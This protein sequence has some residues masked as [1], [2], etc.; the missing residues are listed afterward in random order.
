M[1]TNIRNGPRDTFIINNILNILANLP[2]QN[3]CFFGNFQ[4]I[5]SKIYL[6]FRKYEITE[7]LNYNFNNNK[8]MSNHHSNKSIFDL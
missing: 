2:K 8:K 6:E 4:K 3:I 7:N 1:Y 5:Y